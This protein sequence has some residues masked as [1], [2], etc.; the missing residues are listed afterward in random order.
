MIGPSKLESIFEIQPSLPHTQPGRLMAELKSPQAASKD[1]VLSSVIHQKGREASLELLDRAGIRGRAGGGFPTAHKWWL[2]ASANESQKF[3]VCNAN[4][5]Q[6]GQGKESW[7]ILTNAEKVIE[8][9]AIAAYCV[10]AQCAYVAIP[11]HAH[12]EIAALENAI[13]RAYQTGKLGKDIPGPGYD[14]E[15]KLIKTPAAHLAGEE[16]ALLE[17]IEGK[18]LQPRKRP[19]LPTSKGLFGKPTAV[20]NLETV[21]QCR[22]A[23]KL[24]VDNYREMGTPQA[25][26]TMVFTLF[27]N[28]KRP[29]LYELPL[30]ATLRDLIFD[31]GGGPSFP[32]DL[33]G[34]FPGGI[35]SSLLGPDSLDVAL[36]F[37]SVRDAGS[38]LGS[39]VVIVIGQETCAVELATRLAEFFRDASCG[40]CSPCKDGTSR[41]YTMLTKINQLQQPSV[42]LSDRSLPA[43]KLPPQ[44]ELTILNNVA[45]GIS[46]TDAVKGLEKISYLC[47]FFRYRGDCHHS[48]EAAGSVLSL[49]NAFPEEFEQHMRDGVCKLTELGG[50]KASALTAAL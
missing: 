33:K 41:T 29:G 15:L 40:K 35:G 36:D 26:G 1:T 9:I 38:D 2:V 31:C 23:L 30:G 28:V 45:R 11:D 16:T 3:F 32:G 50:S 17:F 42:D 5:A 10:A 48:T 12:A 49:L 34:I 13:C 24:G 7:F 37:D 46:Y 22:L 6:P 8:A 19:P 14:L 44:T 21:L 20:S 27:G 43:S 4:L 18:A 25:P 47:E 39:G